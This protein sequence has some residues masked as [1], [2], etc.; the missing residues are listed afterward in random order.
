MLLKMTSVKQVLSGAVGSPTC[1]DSSYDGD[2]GDS[3]VGVL[4][5]YWPGISG[6]QFPEAA[7][8]SGLGKKVFE[9]IIHETIAHIHSYFLCLYLEYLMELINSQN[10][11]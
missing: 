2:R 10:T 5:W 4:L 1:L 8:V 3:W 11:L 6:G 7:R 9:F